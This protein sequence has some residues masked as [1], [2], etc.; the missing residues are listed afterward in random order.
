MLSTALPKPW[1]MFQLMYWSLSAL[2]NMSGVAFVS[3]GGSY[4]LLL[5][6]MLD[7]RFARGS[8][9]QASML[10][11]GGSHDDLL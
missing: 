8:F 2:H 6:P 3:T 5:L 9:P 4:I 11:S 7:L 10:D 1:N